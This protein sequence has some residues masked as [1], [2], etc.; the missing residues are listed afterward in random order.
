M[1]EENL[2]NIFFFHKQINHID[3]F[4][5]SWSFEKGNISLIKVG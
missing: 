5:V 3:L 4:F 1:S 2:M